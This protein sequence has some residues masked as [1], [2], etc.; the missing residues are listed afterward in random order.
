MRDEVAG[1]CAAEEGKQWFKTQ[2]T[3]LHPGVNLQL[4]TSQ[5]W[6]LFC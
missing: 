3:D 4:L 1:D 6:V 2:Q 5:T